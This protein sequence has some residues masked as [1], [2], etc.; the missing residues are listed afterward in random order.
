[1]VEQ[2]AAIFIQVLTGKHLKLNCGYTYVCR[3]ILLL[4]V[5]LIW[6]VHLWR[7]IIDE[8]R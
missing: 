6:L 1:M 2:Y 5:L 4:A 8:S 3:L 7:V